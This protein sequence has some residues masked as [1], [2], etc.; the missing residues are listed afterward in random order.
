MKSRHSLGVTLGFLL[1]IAVICLPN[2]AYSQIQ[3]GSFE[4]G[5][6]PG[7]FLTLTAPDSTNI[8]NWVVSGGTIDYIGTVWASADGSRSIDLSGSVGSAG[9]IQQTFTT[10]PNASYTIT[11]SFAGNPAGAPTIKNLQVSASPC[12][13]CSP[14]NYT[15]DTTGYTLTNMGWGDTTYSFVASSTSTTI[16]FTSLDNTGYGPALDNVRSSYTLPP[17]PPTPSTGVN[18]HMVLALGLLSITAGILI[19]KKYRAS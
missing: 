6:N 5:T 4:N 3:N 11:F 10:I 19:F 18:L 7:S 8:N 16:T 15:F 12:S 1:I 2:L 14:Q 17:P 13:G 9:A